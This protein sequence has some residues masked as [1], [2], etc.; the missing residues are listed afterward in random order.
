MAGRWL[1]GS[2]VRGSR[3]RACSRAKLQ[4]SLVASLAGAAFAVAGC[5]DT[6]PPAAAPRPAAAPTEDRR[7]TS[8]AV[9]ENVRH[10]LERIA[11][12]DP[13]FAR[14]LPTRPSEDE[15]RA[16]AVKALAEGDPDVSVRDGALDF[17]SFTARARALDEAQ[18][19]ALGSPEPTTDTRVEGAPLARPRLERELALRVVAEETA[20]LEEE[21]S[22][23]RG[24]SGLVR[25]IVETWVPPGSTRDAA[26][27]DAW[28]AKRLGQIRDSLG[29]ASLPRDALL[30]L[31]DS[32]D[33][34][35]RIAV[36]EELP[37]SAR[38][39]AELRI[40]V[41]ETPAS[42]R[43]SDD[44]RQ[45][46]F[47]AG[48]SA[49]LGLSRATELLARIEEAE[50]TTRSLAREAMKNAA[51]RKEPGADE[52]AVSKRAE[53]LTLAAGKCDASPADSRVR[54]MAPPPERSAVCGSLRALHDADD[55]ASQAAALVALH[56]ATVVARWALALHF[57]GVSPEGAIG[58]AHPFFG[59]Q[60][61][62]QA[63]LLRFAEANPVAAIGAGLAA[64]LLTRNR[65][66]EGAKAASARWLAFGDAPLDVVERE[67][68]APSPAAPI[69][70][71]G[72]PASP[73]P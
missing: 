61:E 36:P 73:R 53:E 59:A 9:D 12:V 23:P 43:G 69:S 66:L 13:R 25:G 29:H 54:S 31:D 56:D 39:V 22:L 17:F 35:E 42:A 14:R 27:R 7:A 10:A 64:E 18:K 2:Q 32:L 70:E 48:V 45:R 60:P 5:A 40:R 41:G 33:P 26:D 52:R 72:R 58:S 19:T 16:G 6:L 15:L 50:K 24:A 44:A 38:A 65:T 37:S 55:G 28:L 30:E 11:V 20:R 71:P 47:E 3:A 51:D 34:I 21:R 62:R 68:F 67:I 1:P 63:H 57:E 8:V 4:W 46:R 49:H